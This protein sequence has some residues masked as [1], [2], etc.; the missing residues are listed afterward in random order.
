MNLQDERVRCPMSGN[1]LKMKDLIPVRF[2]LI[3]D[4]DDKRS[5]IVKDNERYMCAVTSDVLNN[6]VC[7]THGYQFSVIAIVFT[8]YQYQPSG[9]GKIMISL[10]ALY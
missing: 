2:T 1:A 4:R 10:S 8:I 7:I 5:L 6:S 3:K 9:Q